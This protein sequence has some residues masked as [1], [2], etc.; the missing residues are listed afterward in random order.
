ML[1]IMTISLLGIGHSNLSA[2]REAFSEQIKANNAP[3]SYYLEFQHIGQ[4]PFRRGVSDSDGVEIIETEFNAL[5][6]H[7][8]DALERARKAAAPLYPVIFLSLMGHYHFFRST[9]NHPRPYDFVLREQPDLELRS[10]S[11]IISSALIEAALK[12]EIEP[13]IDFLKYLVKRLPYRM[14]HYSSPPP[15]PD[16][17]FLCGI[18]HIETTIKSH[19]ISPAAFRLK[20]WILQERIY[21]EACA[22]L[23]IGYIGPAPRT[24]DEQGFLIRD[25]WTEDGFHGNLAYGQ[26][27]LQHVVNAIVENGATDV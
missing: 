4:E 13:C 19:G 14:F 18:R 15:I 26:V 17:Q 10:D 1:A 21:R 11:E 2:L 27:M 6:G 25:Y 9:T 16:N 7:V 12:R 23:N 8:E 3:A 24:H 20:M 22:R 5:P